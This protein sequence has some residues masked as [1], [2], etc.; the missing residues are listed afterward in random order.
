[1]V[2]G[3][4]L[5][6]A[7]IALLVYNTY[8]DSRAGASVAAVADALESIRQAD[9]EAV[10]YV[11]APSQEQENEVSEESLPF[12]SEPEATEEAIAVAEVDGYTYMGTLSIP[13]LSLE[14]PIQYEWS[15]PGLKISPGRYS[16]SVWGNNL[17][18]CGHNYTSHF[19]K[20]KRLLPGDTVIFTDLLGNAFYYTVSEVV[21]L[22]PTDVSQML[23]ELDGEWDLTLFTCT[24]GG[25]TRVTVRCSKAEE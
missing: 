2:L 5:L 8:E 11:P 12:A 9:S 25:Q 3:V 10:S 13:S 4:V 20:L 21:T 6:A 24:L 23:S 15:Y 7:A 19:G 14:L 22:Q 18:I 1:M 16:G 17:V